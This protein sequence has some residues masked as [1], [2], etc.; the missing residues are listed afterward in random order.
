M[1]ALYGIVFVGVCV[2]LV[3]IYLYKYKLMSFHTGFN[4]L[5]ALWMLL[6]FLFFLS[7]AFPPMPLWVNRIMYWPTT[8]VQFA[9]YSLLV[10][11]FVSYVYR[12]KWS[13]LVRKRVYFIYIFGNL[14]LLTFTLCNTIVSPLLRANTC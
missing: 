13:L 5:V 12:E 1:C 6:R 2:Q 10:C 11:F 3:K 4:L 9:T 14:A 7:L 8:N